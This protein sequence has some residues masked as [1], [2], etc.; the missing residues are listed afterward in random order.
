M[1]LTAANLP[2]YLLLV[3]CCTATEYETAILIREGFQPSEK[4]CISGYQLFDHVVSISNLLV[5]KS[6]LIKD[7][8]EDDSKI[9]V[10]TCPRR[11]GKSLNMGMLKAF[12]QIQGSHSTTT[13]SYRM[14]L[15]GEIHDFR[16]DWHF[17][18][19]KKF[20]NFFLI[21]K[22]KHI[23]DKYL[24]QYPVIYIS[25]EV[26]GGNFDGWINQF[27]NSIKRTFK[28]HENTSAVYEAV[29]KDKNT[30]NS[31][32]ADARRRY[33]KFES[34]KNGYS[35]QPLE[36]DQNKT[37]EMIESMRFLSETLYKYYKRK[38]IILMDKYFQP[39]ETIF[40]DKDFKE[41]DKEKCLNFYTS[42]MAA[43]FKDNP[44]LEKAVITGVLPPSMEL[45]KQALPNATECNLLNGKFMQ[46]YGF[47][48]WEVEELF[49]SL[50][51]SYPTRQEVDRW[52]KGYKANNK[53]LV[54]YN[55]VSIAG[56]LNENNTDNHWCQTGG[57]GRLFENFLKV[58]SF[59]KKWLLLKNGGSIIVNPDSQ[60]F[61]WADYAFLL[62]AN[63]DCVDVDVGDKF[64]DK[65]FMLLHAT[66]YLTL[67]QNT[68]RA[69]QL[70]YMKFP[71]EEI[72]T[73]T[74]LQ[75]RISEDP[76]NFAQK[77]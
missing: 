33:D 3:T 67:A 44:Y 59:M 63:V 32:K 76:L 57:F 12:F 39:W 14:F 1:V 75:L 36:I 25:L 38:V 77:S 46:H 34:L 6:L 51:T 65:A 62:K 26:L 68:D 56:F 19:M 47:N 71:N 15:N 23:I 24:G 42:F 53:D 70:Y 11:W 17:K 60:Y 16:Y 54:I 5:D 48:Q 8:V 10:I 74:L 72:R 45:L 43:T 64:T 7:M 41:D 27:K 21:A 35:G 20:K 18:K 69:P 31:T 4:P 73:S 22:H 61:T 37:R 9:Y 49:D 52:Y 50:N 13:P 28:E 30:D 2:A 66:G 58:D 29:T 40:L 55:A